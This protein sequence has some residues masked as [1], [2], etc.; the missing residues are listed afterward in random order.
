MPDWPRLDRAAAAQ[1]G[2]GGDSRQAAPH[3]A[4]AHLYPYYRASRYSRYEPDRRSRSPRDRSADRFERG[5]QYGDGDRRRSSA[6]ARSTSSG[7]QSSRDSFG[8]PVRREPP[9]G[10]KALVEP[11]SGPRG[12]SFASDFRGSRGRGRGLAWPARDDSRDRGR[13]RDLEYRDRDRDRR[14]SRDFRSRR[15]PPGRAR[16]PVRDFRDRDRDR[17]ALS[18]VDADRARRDSRDGGPPSAGSA[19]SDP[20]FGMFPFGRGGS[21]IRARGRGGRG[22]WASSDRGRTRTTFDDRGDRYPRSRSQEGRWGRERDERDRG[23]RYPDPDIRCDSR[24]ECDRGDRDVIRSKKEGRSSIPQDLASQPKDVSPPPVAPSAPAFGS[25]PSRTASGGD[26]ST[27]AGTAKA[28]PTAPRAFSE[29]PVSSGGDSSVAPSG[30][31]RSTAH[32]H[33]PIPA[34]P[35]AQQQRPSSKQWINPDLKKAPE[36]PKM[37]RPQTFAQPSPALIRR[38]SSHADQYGEHGRPGSS[39]AKPSPRASSFEA[40]ARSRHSA[41]PG[42]IALKSEP[43]TR[44]QGDH[45]DGNATYAAL[46]SPDE[47]HDGV[48]C[49]RNPKTLMLEVAGASKPQG[50]KRKR[51]RIVVPVVRFAL[52]PKFSITQQDSE[53]DDDEMA[54][55]FDNE[56]KKT[57]SELSRLPAPSLPRDVVAHYAAMSHGAMVQIL[58]ESEGLTG[59]MGPILQES[60]VDGT[61]RSE[62]VSGE[63]MA[64]DSKEPDP[65][66]GAS[67]TVSEAKELAIAETQADETTSPFQTEPA[68]KTEEMDIDVPAGDISAAPDTLPTHAQPDGEIPRASPGPDSLAKREDAPVQDDAFRMVLEPAGQGSKPSSTASQVA[69]EDDDETETEDEGYVEGDTLRKFMTT[70]PVDSLPDYSCTDW[71]KDREFLASLDPDP[72]MTDIVT[73]HLCKVHIQEAEARSHNQKEYAE[74]YVRYLDFTMSNDP[75]A[76]KSRDKFSLAAP[77][78]EGGGAVTPEAKPEGRGTGRRFATERDL[79]RVLQVSMREDEERRDRELRAKKEK[80]RSDKE[81]VIPDMLSS[82][83]RSIAQYMDRSGFTPQD[84]LVAAW[85]VLPPVNNFTQEETELFEKRYLELPK[86]W[87]KVAEAIPNRDFGTC[88]QYYYSMK[89]ALNL[90]EKLKKQ[91]KR[92]KKGGRGKQRSSALVSELGNGDQEG[93]ENPETGDNGERRRPRRAAAPTWGFEQPATDSENATPAGTPGRRGASAA[94]K[95]DPPEKTD[96]RKGRRKVAKDKEPKTTKAAQALATASTPTGARGRSSSSSRAPNSEFPTPAPPDTN[97]RTAAPSKQQQQQPVPAPVPPGIHAPFAVQQQP[98]HMVEWPKPLAASSISEVMA[99]PSLRPEPP[100]LPQPSMTTFNLAQPQ[101]ERKA[102]TQASSYWSVSEANDFPHL[103]RSYGTD[104]TS[105]AAYMGSKTA[106]MVSLL[107]SGTIAEGRA[108]GCISRSRTTL[109]GR[110]TMASRNGRPSSKKRMPNAQEARNGPTLRS[111]RSV[112]EAEDMTPRRPAHLDPLPWPQ[113]WTS[114]VNPHSPRRTSPRSSRAPK[115]SLAMASCPSRRHRRSKRS[116][117]PANSRWQ[118]SSMPCLSQRRRPCRP[119][120]GRCEHPSSTSDS[121]IASASRSLNRNIRT[122]GSSHF[123][124]KPEPALAMS[125]SSANS[126]PLPPHSLSSLPAPTS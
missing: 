55:Y 115:H 111:R 79:E 59:M 61:D 14:D 21:Y 119:P 9:R 69:D 91:P 51:S 107:L 5:S 34:G 52:P 15:S 62:Q 60:P 31:S 10:P 87:G 110:R 3:P 90:K 46:T 84:R 80:Y 7:F 39:D 114:R 82:E 1:A 44:H 4:P 92:R 102:P 106:V 100:P 105:I 22:D 103:L 74:N 64:V 81:A 6:E 67:L 32:D 41:E 27:L 42:E 95:G 125:L 73:A 28:P 58:N 40:Q 77:A 57:E 37:M 72:G 71:T 19:S 89:K 99:V 24:D 85:Q 117:S 56:S 96:G 29:R 120:V 75:A 98:A 94:A 16:S 12:G 65:E 43:E 38:G 68:T 30:S 49:I 76:V 113:A 20:Q 116:P 109:S 33:P 50:T 63:P 101:T 26:G 45:G 112:A 35:R 86:Q 78:L 8:D 97:A 18:G 104:W 11:P 93:E 83:E 48:I 66:Q 47:L 108:D 2:L 25:V 118:C 122:K 121:P 123:L 70:P 17:D 126:A 88:I 23:D 124:Q 54:E 13:E 36:S 53:S